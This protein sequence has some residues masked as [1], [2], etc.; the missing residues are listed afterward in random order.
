MRGQ[1]VGGPESPAPAL[2]YSLFLPNY[3]L[4]LAASACSVAWRVPRVVPRVSRLVVIRAFQ[5]LLSLR[6]LKS[7]ALA[8]A[9]AAVAAC[10]SD[11]S[12]VTA[13]ATP[14]PPVVRVPTVIS[15]VLRDS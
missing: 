10:G 13:P 8:V 9:W 7:A 6:V 15:L 2:R 4:R 1:P 3:R 11:R 14:A 12:P 5:G